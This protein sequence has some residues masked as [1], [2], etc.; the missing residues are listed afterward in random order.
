LKDIERRLWELRSLPNAIPTLEE[1]ELSNELE[2]RK[3]A[4][5]LRQRAGG[6]STGRLRAAKK[7]IRQ[8]IIEEFLYPSDERAAPEQ[9]QPK[10]GKSPQPEFKLTEYQCK[11]PFSV[12]TLESFVDF[13]RDLNLDGNSEETIRRDIKEVL[14]RRSN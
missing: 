6:Q 3:S 9:S 14:R 2:L 10:I 12:K 7:R 11:H 8:F 4:A 13:F 1:I 5:R